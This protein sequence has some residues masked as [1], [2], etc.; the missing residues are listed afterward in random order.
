[1]SRLGL[2]VLLLTA[3]V[4]PSC[5]VPPDGLAVFMDE[6]YTA[7]VVATSSNGFASADGIAWH[8]GRMYLADDRGNAV[9]VE[10]PEHSFMPLATR[11]AGLRTLE[12]L[13]VD[14]DGTVFCTDD[15]A[16]GVWQ[17]SPSGEISQLVAKSAGLLSTEGLVIAPNGNLLVGDGGSH[18]IFEVT[19]RGEVTTFLGPEA[20]ISKPESL[21]MDPAGNL[22]VADN[23][24]NVIYR[25]DR[26]RRVVPLITSKDGLTQPES[27]CYL[28][29]GLYITD[30]ETGKLYRYTES[31]GVRPVAVFGGRLRGLQNI[32][33]GPGCSL[34]VTVQDRKHTTG[35]VLKITCDSRD[36]ELSYATHSQG[37]KASWGR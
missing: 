14:E 6:R 32:T 22:Y 7:A 15:H 21:A 36:G 37:S 18:T 9:L 24:Q 30:D 28:N 16:G 34:L 10:T 27:I 19:R 4:L 33:V 11:A 29:G 1:M 20:G 5:N 13:I 25:V 8:N 17:I 35:L 12:D 26:D 2:I 23:L 3:V 31:D